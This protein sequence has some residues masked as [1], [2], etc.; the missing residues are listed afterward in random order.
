MTIRLC[1]LFAALGLLAASCGDDGSSADEQ[2]T[3]TTSEATVVDDE[4]A[5]EDDPAV[6]P[7]PEPDEPIE[8]PGP[9]DG[10]RTD[11][12]QCLLDWGGVETPNADTSSGGADGGARVR[13]GRMGQWKFCTS[14]ISMR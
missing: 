4:P 8:E 10:E 9:Y 2:P 7:A 14:V 11:A 1:A 12:R 5:P 13:A 3:T 6:D